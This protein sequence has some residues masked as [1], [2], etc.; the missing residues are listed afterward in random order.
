MSDDL[1]TPGFWNCAKDEPIGRIS[2]ALR[3]PETFAVEIS[4]FDW[5]DD[6]HVLDELARA[7]AFPDSFERTWDG[8][9]E[10]LDGFRAVR[11]KCLIVF[12][13]IPDSD[14]ARQNV[15]RAADLLQA[16]F[17]SPED[18]QVVLDDWN[19]PTLDVQWPNAARSWPVRRLKTS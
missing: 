11:P 3:I 4:A 17:P 9:V 16:G 6:A 18:Q 5:D 12:R 14:L 10:A 8:V 1:S 19:G 2:R 7:F 15:A 13:D